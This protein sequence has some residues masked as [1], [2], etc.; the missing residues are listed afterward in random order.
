MVDV[1]IP[2]VSLHGGQLYV[3]RPLSW[4]HITSSDRPPHQVTDHHIKFFEQLVKVAAVLTFVIVI[5]VFIFSHWV[6]F[7]VQARRRNLGTTC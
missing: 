1:A 6:L 4:R 3:A 7:A 5:F 2:D